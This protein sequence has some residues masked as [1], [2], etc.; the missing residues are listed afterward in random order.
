MRGLLLAALLLLIAGGAMAQ[1]VPVQSG[2][3]AGFT[4][5]VAR[6]GADTDWELTRDGRDLR[7]AF[8]PEA[9]AFDLSGVFQRIPRDRLAAITDDEG[10]ELSLGCDCRVDLSRYQQRYLVID[11]SDAP[12]PPDPDPDPEPVLEL[13][14]FTERAS[15]PEL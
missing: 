10:L 6:I 7:I 13:P 9:P 4:R 8:T 5:L 2:E 1:G 15:L 14:L 3:H 12:A 11:I